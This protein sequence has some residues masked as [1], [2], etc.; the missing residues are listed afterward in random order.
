MTSHWRWTSPGLGLYVRTGIAF[1]VSG[2]SG[3]QRAAPLDDALAT[4]LAVPSSGE[5]NGLADYLCAP[6]GVKVTPGLRCPTV[7][8]EIANTTYRA[9][10]TRPSSHTGSSDS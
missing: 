10:S 1:V 8:R 6:K 4:V 2:R 7:P 9:R 5:H 3:C